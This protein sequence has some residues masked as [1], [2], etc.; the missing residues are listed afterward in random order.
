MTEQAAQPQFG[1]QRIY[2][3][4]SSFEAPGAPEIFRKEW[5]P[6]INLN[7]NTN[8]KKLEEGVYEVTLMLTVTAKIGEDTGFIAEVQQAG[9][10]QVSNF[11][12]QQ[13]QH[14]LGAYAPNILFPYARTVIDQLVSQGSF[15]PVLLAPVNFDALFQQAQ[16]QKNAEAENAKGGET[17]Q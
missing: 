13:T 5:K 6:E 4:D 1:I 16:A 2:V 8:A 7:M 14:M 15:P 17:I 12:E 9:I 10:F 3:K 11:P